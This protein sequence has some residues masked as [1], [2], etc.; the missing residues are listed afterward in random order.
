MVRSR[1]VTVL[2]SLAAALLPFWVLA[3]VKAVRA[4]RRREDWVTAEDRL[5]LPS[6]SPKVSVLIAARN[7]EATI[8]P[9][10]DAFLAQTYPTFEVIVVDDRSEDRTYEVAME[11]AS[12][13]RLKVRR[14]GELPEGWNGKPH[15]L[16]LA[17]AEADGEWLL[18]TDA[19]TVHR[20]RSIENGIAYA[21]LRGADAVSTVGEMIHPSLIS[22]LV[23]PQLYAILAATLERKKRRGEQTHE[24]WGA[25]GGYFLMTREAFDRAGGMEGVKDA[26]AEDAALAKR[27]H[28]TGA[29]YAFGLGAPALWR[30]ESYRS[31]AEIYRG[32]ARNESFRL[33]SGAKLLGLTLLMWTLALVPTAAMLGALWTD[34]YLLLGIGQ[35]AVVLFVQANVRRL[36]RTKWW[37][38]PL[39][40]VGALLAWGMLAGWFFRGGAPITWKG[41]VYR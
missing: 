18:L 30:T 15:A 4:K 20:P 29:K 22:N 17:A 26:I 16:H 24:V 40:P 33:G 28:E 37:L 31:L 13:E 21:K 1:A 8:G 6:P 23:T 3:L 14:S 36:S 2:V 10:L 9:C 19:D 32:Y 35:Y 5:A 27:L 12:D 38:A 25:C 7:E 39:A 41:R 11:R 34:R